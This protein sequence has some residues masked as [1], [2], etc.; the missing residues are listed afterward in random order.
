MANV[1]ATKIAVFLFLVTLTSILAASSVLSAHNLPVNVVCNYSTGKLSPEDGFEIGD[2]DQLAEALRGGTSGCGFQ[3]TVSPL[4]QSGKRLGDIYYERDDLNFEIPSEDNYYWDCDGTRYEE[5][6]CTATDCILSYDYFNDPVYGEYD[7][8]G[9]CYDSCTLQSETIFFGNTTQD[10]LILDLDKMWSYFNILPA[11]ETPDVSLIRFVEDPF[12]LLNASSSDYTPGFWNFHDTCDNPY[13]CRRTGLDCESRNVKGGFNSTTECLVYELNKKLADCKGTIVG[14][15]KCCGDDDFIDPGFEAKTNEQNLQVW[16]TSGESC[17]YS[18]WCRRVKDVA[19]SGEQ[20]F[21]IVPSNESNSLLRQDFV[22]QGRQNGQSALIMPTIPAGN[23]RVSFWVKGRNVP[24]GSYALLNKTATPVST[25]IPE[26][27]Y[28]WKHVQIPMTLPGPQQLRYFEIVVPSLPNPEDVGKSRLWIDDVHL[29]HES[30]AFVD[31]GKIHRDTTGEDTPWFCYHNN[32]QWSWLNPAEEDFK[33]KPINGFNVISNSLG[34]HACNASGSA[35][36]AYESASDISFTQNLRTLSYEAPIGIPTLITPEEL[37]GEVSNYGVGPNTALIPDNQFEPGIS[38]WDIQPSEA[39]AHCYNELTDEG[40]S[41]VDCGDGCAKCWDGQKCSTDD[42]CISGICRDD[43]TGTL[44]CAGEIPDLDQA[45]WLA[46][47]FICS[48]MDGISEYTECCGYSLGLCKNEDLGSQTRRA[49][50]P[51]YDIFEFPKDNSNINYALAIGMP[52]QIPQDY[53]HYPFIIENADNPL[54]NWTDTL[55]LEFYI[56]YAIAPEQKYLRLLVSDY[57]PSSQFTETSLQDYLNEDIPGKVLFD[58]YVDDYVTGQIQAGKW[59]RVVI[60]VEDGEIIPSNSTRILVLYADKEDVPQRLMTHE[61]FGTL[62]LRNALAIDRIHLGP[63]GNVNNQYRRYCAKYPQEDVGYWVSEMDQNDS[64][65]SGFPV[66][67]GVCENTPGFG[68][69]G[70]ACCGDDLA[71]TSLLR[72]QES[73][74]VAES[75]ADTLHGCVKGFTVRNNSVMNLSYANPAGG[76]GSASLLYFNGLFYTCKSKDKADAIKAELEYGG[77]STGRPYSLD[78]SDALDSVEGECDV[79]GSWYCDFDK[80]WKNT[81][82]IPGETINFS[83]HIPFD[84]NAKACCP[85]NWCFYGNVSAPK[86]CVPSQADIFQYEEQEGLPYFFNSSK[87]YGRVYGNNEYYRCINGNWRP[88]VLKWNPENTDKGYCPQIDQCYLGPEKGCV[89]T[90][91]FEGDDYCEKGNWSSRTKLVARQ[92][93]DILEEK[94]AAITGYDFK[95]GTIYCDDFDEV[96]AQVDYK[97]IELSEKTVRELIEGP[98]EGCPGTDGLP[99][100]NN[101]C[102]LSLVDLDGNEEVYIGTS[103][104]IPLNTETEYSL[105]RLFPEAKGSAGG[106]HNIYCD[107]AIQQSSITKNYTGCDDYDFVEAGNA[108]IWVDNKTQTVIYSRDAF[109]ISNTVTTSD[110]F[111]MMIRHPLRTIFRWAR[112]FLVGEVETIRG[113]EQFL[114]NIADLRK[115]Y[116]SMASNKEIRGAVERKAGTGG[117]QRNIMTVGYKNV[118]ENL[119]HSNETIEALRLEDIGSTASCNVRINSTEVWQNLYAENIIYWKDLTVNTR[120]QGTYTPEG[121]ESSVGIQGPAATAAGEPASYLVTVYP[122]EEEEIIATSV[123]FDDGTA[124]SI[125]GV[126]PGN[127]KVITHTFEEGGNYKVVAGILTSDFKIST[128]DVT[129]TNLP[130]ITENYNM[131]ENT[132]LEPTSLLIDLSSDYSGFA[133]SISIVGA[134][135]DAWLGCN[136]I[137]DFEINCTPAVNQ[138]GVGKLTID[139]N[140]E[141][142][143]LQKIL[144]ITVH[145]VNTPPEFTAIPEQESPED[146]APESSWSVNLADYVYDVE[147]ADASLIFESEP[148]TDGDEALLAGFGCGISNQV[149]SCSDYIEDYTGTFRARITVGDTGDLPGSYNDQK[150]ATQKLNITITNVNDAPEW[151]KDPQGNI[152][153][154]EELIMGWGSTRELKVEDYVSDIDDAP[155]NLTIQCTFIDTFTDVQTTQITFSEGKLFITSSDIDDIDNYECYGEDDD[156]ETTDS[157]QLKINVTKDR[158]PPELSLVEPF[159]EFVNEGEI[160]EVNLTVEDTEEPDTFTFNYSLISPSVPYITRDIRDWT[161]ITK[162]QEYNATFLWNTSHRIYTDNPVTEM[163]PANEEY[164]FKFNVTDIN[165]ILDE[166]TQGFMLNRRPAANISLGLYITFTNGII[167]VYNGSFVIYFNASDYDNLST[168]RLDWGDGTITSYDCANTDFFEVNGTNIQFHEY[169]VIGEYNISINATDTKGASSG[170]WE[171]NELKPIQLSAYYPDATPPTTEITSLEVSGNTL[172]LDY[173]V[174]DNLSYCGYF[175]DKSVSDVEQQVLINFDKDWSRIDC[176]GASQSGSVSVSFSDEGYHQ[177]VFFSADTMGR[178]NFSEPQMFVIDITDPVI[179][180]ILPDSDITIGGTSTTATISVEV[181]DN[182]GVQHIMYELTD[183]AGASVA[184]KEQTYSN[185]TPAVLQGSATLNAGETYTL[186]A[187]AT[188]AGD[189]TVTDSRTFSVTQT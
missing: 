13:G 158:V 30:R 122:A 163:P 49:G 1:S 125:S 10:D 86:S 177:I 155:E 39:P 116:I 139:I 143:T 185:I 182:V 151:K 138:N 127:A 71:S 6:S 21:L 174:Q 157:V 95:R 8:D 183:S 57:A 146:Q 106:A 3:V 167:Q 45:G 153:F 186:T 61:V 160:L 37:E 172:T 80:V 188:D 137:D 114:E 87:K 25:S 43:G 75:Y 147:T 170:I 135:T 101:F 18:S 42:D 72:L 19:H 145:P 64:D 117:L 104:N 132:T 69:T 96:L 144:E 93:L 31:Y 53:Y 130:P 22:H 184:D 108:N 126:P 187:E 124:V 76:P 141:A 11:E 17:Q 65:V 169:Q 154:P 60:P 5:D 29:I 152:L 136:K 33:I 165:A 47:R 118:E 97:D 15:Y 88:A 36:L 164:V 14:D 54:Y 115:L 121:A 77:S 63:G 98:S 78:Y 150:T 62:R 51:L 129:T 16:E 90:G 12:V 142:G 92:L 67:K 89:D 56:A 159:A 24:A 23:F 38:L 83:V 110:V 91:Y 27:T 176:T 134:E 28:D 68:W 84:A 123:D 148:A 109:D 120:L 100:A 103:T 179:E 79:K 168:C 140:T 112:L 180:E 99:C 4:D 40:E 156:G 50:N 119:C 81:S 94:R 73:G 162:W 20:S 74:V 181:T 105:L 102:A 131:M 7:C 41:D 161:N 107:G 59:M 9:E 133:E 46:Q 113:T 48:D 70:N 128:D 85:E 175:T 111:N 32:T 35:S 58:G 44:R 189:N 34:W 82:A 2:L 166:V 149:F 66:G 26:G 173:A 178:V 52:L 171:N 55:N